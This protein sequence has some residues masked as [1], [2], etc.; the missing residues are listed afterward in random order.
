MKRR[1]KHIL[2]YTIAIMSMAL[3]AQTTTENYVVGKTYKVESQTPLT[4][5]DPRQVLKS[6]QYI[7]GLGRMKQSVIMKGGKRTYDVNQNINSKDIVIYVEYDGFGRQA[8]EYLPYPSLHTD[9]RFE[10]NAKNDTHSY[11][12]SNYADDF[13]GVANALDAN[14]FSKKIFD[15]SSL[16]R[17][18]EQT[19]PGTD[20]K[21]G[22][23]TVT[24]KAYSNG[25]TVR[26]E[27][28]TNTTSE[29]KVFSVTTTF[30]NNTYTPTL[31]GGTNYYAV[32]ELTKMVTKDENWSTNDG[33]NRTTEEFKN[34]SGQV[35]LKRT[36]GQVDLNGDGIQNDGATG[37][38]MYW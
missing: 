25:H 28:D 31:V 34:K 20:W 24:G 33:T 19:A 22:S 36:Y 14:V 9:G 30:A 11:Y 12:F 5:D 35:I 17:M 15:N 37:I 21:Q 6:I 16:N 26:M 32:G 10:T 7:D 2:G 13:T 4:T 1:I 29:V 3:G 27:Y 8:K 23:T 38:E 18:V